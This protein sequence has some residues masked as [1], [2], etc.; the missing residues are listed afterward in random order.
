MK[1]WWGIAV[2]LVGLVWPGGV[3][4]ESGF[5]IRRF[6]TQIEVERNT[7]L[8]VV[9]RIDVEF[10]EPRHGIYRNIPA[11]RIKVLEVEDEKQVKYKYSAKR[12]GGMM[13]VKIGDP[14]VTISGIRVYIITYEVEDMVKRYADHDEVYWNVTGSDW[15]VP[16]RQATAEVVSPWAE[17]IKTTCY[18][19]VPG[20]REGCRVVG[21]VFSARGE[22]GQGKDMTIVVGLDKN[23]E[24]IWPAW[25]AKVLRDFLRY[26]LALIPG[27]VMG[28][29]WYM[30][31]RDV[32]YRDDNVYAPDFSKGQEVVPAWQREHLPLVYTPIRGLTPAEAGTIIDQKVDIADVVA[33]IVE[34]ARLGYIEIKKVEKKKWL[35][36]DVD[37]WFVASG[38][39]RAGLREYQKML[40]EDISQTGMFGPGPEKLATVY[41]HKAGEMA[42]KVTALSEMKGKF[43]R[44]LENF[45]ESLYD[46]LDK[47]GIFDGRPDKIRFGVVMAVII[48]T[49]VGARF[50]L[51]TGLFAWAGDRLWGGLFLVSCAAAVG[52]AYFLPRRTARGH[53]LYRQLVGLKYFV[54]EGRWRYEIGEK[55]LFLEE[56]L[57]LS[58]SLGVV[59]KLTAEMKE[60]GMEPPRYA[61]NMS[62]GQFSSFGGYVGKTLAYQASRGWSGGS[63]FSGGSS[64]GGGGGGGGGSW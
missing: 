3:R 8:K 54:G 23:N 24:L 18:E 40:L 48:V 36:K 27:L 34:L 7:K 56:I 4:G 6:E 57:P 45:K 14:Q 33:E 22:V 37:Y 55:N 44:H 51:M 49:V 61:G 17:I 64:G 59:G 47:G 32:R 43:Y 10:Y 21:S 30:K 46:Y 63:G 2:V 29:V 53:A 38:R 15:E 25:W 50:G 31:G 52:F 39:D 42:K 58:I 5:E 9:E 19:G 12:T 13:E 26:G 41:G 28:M 1:K 11:E 35:G 60:L 16:I 20:S 62:G